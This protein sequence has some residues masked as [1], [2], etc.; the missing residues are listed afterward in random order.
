MWEKSTHITVPNIKHTQG[1]STV[2]CNWPAG[3]SGI[4]FPVS[5]RPKVSEHVGGWEKT[6]TLYLKKTSVVGGADPNLRLAG[7]TQLVRVGTRQCLLDVSARSSVCRN[8]RYYILNP[9][10]VASRYL[11]PRM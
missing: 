8:G 10:T 9:S 2:P 11:L 1:T 4:D 3:P 5:A 6:K 7:A